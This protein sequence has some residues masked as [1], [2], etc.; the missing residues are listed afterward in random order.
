MCNPA[1]RRLLQNVF[2]GREKPADAPQLDVG[3]Y[4][5]RWACPTASLRLCA[6]PAIVKRYVPGER[7]PRIGGLC[8]WS[9]KAEDILRASTVG[10]R[11]REGRMPVRAGGR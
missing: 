5:A 9:N 8:R 3:G 10:E 6:Q 4:D 1:G 2:P 11:F 7:G